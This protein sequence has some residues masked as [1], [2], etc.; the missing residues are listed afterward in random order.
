MRWHGDGQ[1]GVHPVVVK[2]AIGAA[3]WFLV[4][5]WLASLGPARSTFASPS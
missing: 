4:V 2:I 1:A 5:T 3:L